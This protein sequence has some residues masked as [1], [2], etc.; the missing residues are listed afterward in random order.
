V[1]EWA[2]AR[3]ESAQKLPASVGVT[4][5]KFVGVYRPVFTWSIS[6]IPDDV[7]LLDSAASG[8][9][10]VLLLRSTPFPIFVLTLN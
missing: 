2:V 4:T 1:F 10:I 6:H 3:E 9:C 8:R 5:G 7:A